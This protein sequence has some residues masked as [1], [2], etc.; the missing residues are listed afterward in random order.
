P[1]QFFNFDLENYKDKEFDPTRDTDKINIQIWTTEGKGKDLNTFISEKK[2]SIYKGKNIQF[3]EIE[4][5]GQKALSHIEDFDANFKTL[6]IYAKNPKTNNFLT[7]TVS[8]RY[9]LNK[10]A[11]DS[12]LRSFEYTD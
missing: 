6:I 10:E 12:I 11:V 4:L 7:I 3:E 8:P 2:D 1:N 5:G 9:D